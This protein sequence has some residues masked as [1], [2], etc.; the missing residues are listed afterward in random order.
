MKVEQIVPAAI[1]SACL[2]AC[3]GSS[4]G[5]NT[6]RPDPPPVSTPAPDPAPPPAPDPDPTPP[7]APEPEPAPEPPPAPEPEPEP[8]PEPSPTPGSS[9]SEVPEEYRDIVRSE[10]TIP[11]VINDDGDIYRYTLDGQTE[12]YDFSSLSNGS[13]ELPIS[14]SYQTEQGAAATASGTLLVYQQP[15][16]VVT[17]VT[18]TQDSG[19]EGNLG[20]FYADDPLGF[21]TPVSTFTDLIAQN[22]IFDYKG[23]AFDGQEEATLNYTMDFGQRT[24]SG[25]IAGFTRTGL[26]DLR[27]AQL[28]SDWYIR[29]EAHLEKAPELEPD[30]A[31]EVYFFGPNAEEL[32]GNV[33]DPKEDGLLG[34]SEVIF[35]GKR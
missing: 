28:R 3:G 26:I 21:S 31:Y 24:G 4:G 32:T 22:A 9:L 20:I 25:S 16:S 6:V 27:P 14:M 8:T 34:G 2:A 29:G 33:Y 23:V 17:G 5:G 11:L 15:Y 12:E 13:T 1:F 19:G 7:P 35:A 10:K 18:W 30:S